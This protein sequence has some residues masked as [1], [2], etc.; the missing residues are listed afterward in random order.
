MLGSILDK[1][2]A[3]RVRWDDVTSVLQGTESVEH[4]ITPALGTTVDVQ[5]ELKLRNVL[6]VRA[7]AKGAGAP[8][9]GDAVTILAAV[10]GA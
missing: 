2:P 4:T 8:A 9:A 7:L 1:R 6:A 5:L 3:G 10:E